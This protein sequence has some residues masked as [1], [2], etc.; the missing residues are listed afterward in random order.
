MSEVNHSEISIKLWPFHLVV[1]GRT[2]VRELGRPLRLLVTGLAVLVLI[3]A[4]SRGAELCS[5]VISLVR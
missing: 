4:A 5:K 3:L 2:A 1:K